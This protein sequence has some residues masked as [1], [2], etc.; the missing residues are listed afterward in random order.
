M[1]NIE[2]LLMIDVTLN[3]IKC[4]NKYLIYKVMNCDNVVYTHYI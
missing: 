1:C 2:V 4:Q 3:F